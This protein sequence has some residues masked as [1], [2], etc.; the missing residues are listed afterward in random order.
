MLYEQKNEAAMIAHLRTT[1]DSP[2]TIEQF[3]QRPQDFS[4]QR[5]LTFA[6]LTVLILRGYK[7][8][9]QNA[10]NKLFSALADLFRVPTASAYCQARQ[11]LKPELFAHLNEVVCQ[12]FYQ[13]AGGEGAVQGWRGH[14]L[15]AGDGT[16]LT[17]PDNAETRAAFS[18]QTN[19]YDQADCVQA[20]CCVLYDLRNDLGLAAALGK[21]Q[22]EKKLLFAELWPATQ[23]NDLLVLDR[24]YA[25][26]AVLAYAQAQKR[27]VIVRLPQRG[28]A[29]ARAFW[30]SQADQ[31]LIALPCPVSARQFV[32][33]P[34]LAESLSR[35]LI[36]VALDNGTTE[37][38]LTTLLDDETYPAS[39]FKQVY[40]WRWNEATCFDRL[41][42]IFE[43]ERF[44]GTSVLA[45][46]QDFYGVLFLASL[47]SVLSQPDEAALQAEAQQR[48]TQTTPQVNHALSYVAL[49]ERVVQLLVGQQP[50]DEVLNELHHLFRKN[51]TRARPGRPLE[52]NKHLRYAYRLRFHKYVK[53]L[54]A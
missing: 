17:L 16:Y 46:E 22:G 48:Q 19:Q 25:D 20:L 24:H 50:V 29:A 43:A 3:R 52:R 34:G 49:V 18:V 30:S 41:K 28:F 9:L 47:E 45:I 36:R 31:Q 5:L 44:S 15:L 53:K 27:H 37:V 32:R 38:L 2:L 40:G 12:D 42:N 7:L 13:L 26:D 21:R 4:R 23:T 14:R 6:R 35:R 10:L 8:A 39:E 54:L 51:P 33:Q 1:L 11:K